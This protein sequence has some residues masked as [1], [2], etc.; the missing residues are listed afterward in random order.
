LP[1]EQYN[2]GY[3]LLKEGLRVIKLMQNPDEIEKYINSKISVKPIMVTIAK[4]FILQE[5]K[6][7]M[8]ETII[9]HPSVDSLSQIQQAIESISWQLGYTEAVWSLIHS[10]F[11]L[12][13]SSNLFDL[14]PHLDWTTVYQRSGGTSSGWRFPHWKVFVPGQVRISPSSMDASKG[15][16]T[17]ADLYIRHLNIPNLHQ[18]VQESLEDAVRCFRADLFTPSLTMLA[19]AVEG[20]ITEM[21][22]ALIR[23]LS[24]SDRVKVKKLQESL[25]SDFS[26]IAKKISA[27]LE[28]YEKQ[29]LFG[30]ISQSSGVRLDSFRGV[31]VWADHV[32]E[33]R[34]LVHYGSRSSAVNDYEKV[35][36]LLLASSSHFKTIY[37]VIS[38]AQEKV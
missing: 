6:A 20:A 37:A 1:D 24:E 21:G 38:A 9:L 10:G 16:L 31:I 33:A 13:F 26:S 2:C 4:G 29:D 23:W 25:E 27:V 35:A 28:L 12:P 30:R 11:L 19:K 3:Q 8:P 18:E 15:K 5:V 32:R 36:T 22:L 34:N 17:D 7:P 14:E